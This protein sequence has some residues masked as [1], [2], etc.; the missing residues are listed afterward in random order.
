M[1]STARP[2]PCA[3]GPPLGPQPGCPIAFPRSGPL[4]CPAGAAIAS[5][6]GVYQYANT[7][8]VLKE[9]P[10]WVTKL[11]AFQ[12]AMV[13]LASGADDG[14][15]LTPAQAAA[16]EAAFAQA[17]GQVGSAA[18]R[19]TLVAWVYA[20]NLADSGK[21]EDGNIMEHDSISFSARQVLGLTACRAA[22]QKRVFVTALACMAQ[23]NQRWHGCGWRP[24]VLLVGLQGMLGWQ[25]C[26]HAGVLAG[27]LPALACA[28]MRAAACRWPCLP[29]GH[30]HL[31]RAAA[32]RAGLCAWGAASLTW[33]VTSLF[34]VRGSQLLFGSQAG[35]PPV[36]LRPK[37]AALKGAPYWPA[38]LHASLQHAGAQLCSV[39]DVSV[40][41][42]A[43][44]LRPPCWGLG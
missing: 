27:R 44:L 37:A 30:P 28:N 16:A 41:C 14:P 9:A 19:G 6:P 29:H 43:M 42:C 24:R 7:T 4:P 32:A 26:L 5:T 35:L 1:A 39:T 12:S 36:M 2:P 33:T 11:P 18:G 20:D 8:L 31:V 23:S 15:G 21:P 10:L 3:A 13:G 34:P 40:R 25:A 22:L 38:G 17:G